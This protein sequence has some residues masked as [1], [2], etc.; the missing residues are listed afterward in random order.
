LK[1][2]LNF[3][4]SLIESDN[5]QISIS[6]QCNILGIHRSGYYYEPVPETKFNLLLMRMM[7]E[8]FLRTPFY[9]IRRMQKYI[10]LCGYFVNLKRIQRLYKKMGLIAVYPRPR[11]T[12][13]DKEHKKYPYLI[14]DLV[15]TYPNQVW[16]T[17]ITYI[18]MEKGYLYLVAIID[19]YSRYVISWKLSN[20]LDN[21]F[22]IEAL[23]EALEQGKPQ[24]FNTDQGVQFTSN[25]FIKT[26]NDQNIQISMDGKGRAFDN[27]FVERLWRNVKYEYLY[28]HSPKDGKE[29][30]EGLKCYFCFYNSQRPHQGLNYEI[31]INVW[32]S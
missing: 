31:P 18:P 22:C 9:G 11:T 6:R 17:D 16:C 29:I 30:Y 4:R 5:N 20:S 15:V 19:W 13:S 12:I 8:Q 26:L 2:D 14:K 25:E 27:I 21:S 7:D 28:L 24:I 32:K 10:E 1:A 23:Q 3:L